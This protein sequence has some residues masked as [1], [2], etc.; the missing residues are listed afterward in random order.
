MTLGW[1]YE[2][3][4]TFN[5]YIYNRVKIKINVFREPITCIYIYVYCTL[6]SKSYLLK[7]STTRIDYRYI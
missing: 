6:F 1:I 4:I 5:I 2:V 3:T 7:I